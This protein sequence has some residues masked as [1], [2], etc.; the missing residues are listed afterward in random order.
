MSCI[1][2]GY[3]IPHV[4]GTC[5]NCGRPAETVHERSENRNNA[6]SNRRQ[7]LR[8]DANLWTENDRIAGISSAILLVSLFLPW[9]GITLFG[10][11]VTEDGLASHGYLSIVMIICLA[12]L[13]YLILRISPVRPVLPSSR[14]HDLLML[15]A[16]AVNFV[17]VVA[18]FIAA[19]GGA[20]WAPLMSR[21]FGS[22][23]GG[24][25]ALAAAV[26]PAKSV[27]NIHIRLYGR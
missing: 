15:A 8:M 12:I 1:R 16:T 27:F 7:P 26:P 22:F 14:T 23:V 3:E 5:P 6:G 20:D 11:S 13:G 4:S 17:L 2:C 24:I 25:A 9:F 10:T 18:G 21:Q 19:P